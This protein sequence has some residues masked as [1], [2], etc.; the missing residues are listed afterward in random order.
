[1]WSTWHSVY[2]GHMVAQRACGTLGTIN[3][4]D[5]SQYGCEANGTVC[6]WDIWRHSVHAG[7][8]AQY[9]HHNRKV[10]AAYVYGYYVEI[11]RF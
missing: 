1:M 5:M 7:H 11:L 10:I 9:L 4:W 2:M 8:L 6:K 3:M